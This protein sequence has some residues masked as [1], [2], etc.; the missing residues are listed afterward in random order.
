MNA[1]S[2]ANGMGWRSWLIGLVSVAWAVTFVLGTW[3]WFS[4]AFGIGSSC[5]HDFSCG[6]DSCAPCAKAHAWVTAGGIGQWVLAAAGVVFLVV[7][8]R[9]PVWRPA[10]TIAACGLIPIAA[11]WF[12]VSTEIAQRSF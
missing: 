12:A 9:R 10:A 8:L 6:Y 3:G 5:T 7:G 4:V 1:A 2:D 11:I